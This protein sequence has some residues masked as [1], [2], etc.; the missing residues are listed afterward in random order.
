MIED[1]LLVTTF[2]EHSKE[3]VVNTPCIQ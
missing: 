2:I 3:Y 1:N